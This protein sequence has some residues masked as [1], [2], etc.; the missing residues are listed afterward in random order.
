MHISRVVISL[1]DN[2]KAL[3]SHTKVLG[4]ALVHKA[5]KIFAKLADYEIRQCHNSMSENEVLRLLEQDFHNWDPKKDHSF[6]PRQ[7]GDFMFKLHTVRAK[8]NIKTDDKLNAQHIVTHL[9]YSLKQQWDWDGSIEDK[10]REIGKWSLFFSDLEELGTPEELFKHL[11]TIE[12]K[13]REAGIAYAAL[14]DRPYFFPGVGT[15]K[16]GW[17]GADACPEF[18]VHSG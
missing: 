12:A 3:I 11:L 15:P 10:L 4:S 1:L 18:A 17:M 7:W 14:G 9:R 13:M 2:I 6:F 8:L 5:E 16:R